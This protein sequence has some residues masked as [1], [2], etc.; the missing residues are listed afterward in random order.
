MEP[1][2]LV[3]ALICLSASAICTTAIVDGLVFE[4]VVD[5]KYLEENFD[6]GIKAHI[7]FFVLDAICAI[8]MLLADSMSWFAFIA[9]F[10]QGLFSAWA[11]KKNIKIL[12]EMATVRLES[13]LR[14]INIIRAV[15]SFA[16]FVMLFGYSVD[17]I[18]KLC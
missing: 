16:R 15:L 14:R 9:L 17:G 3:N 12:D 7:G 1:L 13:E 10:L 18:Y 4:G 6:R 11:Y 2:V 8:I 5:P